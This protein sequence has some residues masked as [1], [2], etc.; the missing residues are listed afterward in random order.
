MA[1]DVKDT[2]KVSQEILG[3]FLSG[4]W[5]RSRLAQSMM[6]PIRRRRYGGPYDVCAEC[7]KRHWELADVS[8]HSKEDCAVYAVMES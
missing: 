3:K 1:D 2:F 8:A 6:E 7:G 5:G 4:S